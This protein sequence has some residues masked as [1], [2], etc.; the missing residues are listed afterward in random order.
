MPTRPLA[1]SAVT[2][3]LS[4]AVTVPTARHLTDQALNDIIEKCKIPI[5]IPLIKTQS[6]KLYKIEQINEWIR[7][8]KPT[9]EKDGEG[10]F[11][12]KFESL[13]IEKRTYLQML[14]IAQITVFA[15]Q[16]GIKIQL[17][18]KSREEI[19]AEI[20]TIVKKRFPKFKFTPSGS[21]I[22]DP[23]NFE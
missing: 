9:W 14:T 21:L 16:L 3:H 7:K 1:S 18:G 17:N 12:A 19:I 22:I 10:F 23:E 11:L 4:V 8:N 13:R 20:N 2:Q 5:K 6:K 15:K